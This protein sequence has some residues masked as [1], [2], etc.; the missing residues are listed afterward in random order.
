MYFC[1]INFFSYF[2]TAVE[3][4]FIKKF[5]EE[6]KDKIDALNIVCTRPKELT[7]EALKSLSLELDLHK[8]TEVQLN[9]AWKELR[10]EDITADIITFIRRLAIGS[11]LISHEQRI[12]NAV[13]K[14]SRNHYF[15]KIELDWLNRIEKQML[16]D[17]ILNKETFESS[18]F[19]TKGGYK[20]MDK[21]FGNKLEEIIAEVND[22]LYE[23]WS[24]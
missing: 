1:I 2:N 19:K 12:K 10:N 20:A 15:S 9:T 7:R 22:Y 6:N 24:A 3:I 8:Y 18:A 21:I 14:L 23:D 16:S 13:A 4:Y 11:P 17:N 5:I